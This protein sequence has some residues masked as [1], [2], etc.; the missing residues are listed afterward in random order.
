MLK[1]L[2][3]YVL[4]LYRHHVVLLTGLKVTMVTASSQMNKADETH[5][6]G[7]SLAAGVEG[8]E[9]DEGRALEE[10]LQQLE[11]E[12]TSKHLK[13]EHLWWAGL[14]RCCRTSAGV[15]P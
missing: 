10:L 1:A 5:S 13:Q 7:Q 15:P 12:Q 14:Q 6:A 2:T 3:A 4:L 9:H 8:P 11:M